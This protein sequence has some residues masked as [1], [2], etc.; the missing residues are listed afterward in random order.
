MKGRKAVT[1]NAVL[2][3]RIINPACSC[4]DPLP[5]RHFAVTL[6]SGVTAAAYSCIMYVTASPT[7]GSS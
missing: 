4:G 2:S 7:A 6:A 5:L 3:G 1:D